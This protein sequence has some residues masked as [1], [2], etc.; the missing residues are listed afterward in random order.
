MPPW[1][2]V[3]PVS[4][5]TDSYD[6]LRRS[7]ERALQTDL[8]EGPAAELAVSIDRTLLE[9]ARNGELTLAYLRLLAVAAYVVVALWT[10]IS[11]ESRGGLG[12]SVGDALLGVAWG[13]GAVSL[14][15]A[16][17]R[18]WYRLWLRHVVPAADA[19]MIW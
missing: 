7:I 18:G 3:D 1:R 10:F 5:A 8:P 15:V 2:T 14:V 19:A 17:R 4:P 13:G 11:P 6:A 12:Y 9:E 16:L